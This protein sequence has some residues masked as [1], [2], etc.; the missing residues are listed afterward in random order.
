MKFIRRILSH[1]MLII[2][3]AG[4]VAIYYVRH[5]VLP[6]TLVEKIDH[7]A[8]M[9]HP[10]LV[11]FK[12]ERFNP[13][14][15]VSQERVT[16]EKRD[17]VSSDKR[18][19]DADVAIVDSVEEPVVV[20]IIE[21]PEQVKSTDIAE[22]KNVNEE[23]LTIEAV[24]DESVADEPVTD[25]SV[26]TVAEPVVVEKDN[27]AAEKPVEP[28]QVVVADSEKSV[29][30]KVAETPADKSAVVPA[31]KTEIKEV[32]VEKQLVPEKDLKAVLPVPVVEIESVTS[33][34]QSADY[35]Q[36]L[37]DAR[38][39]YIDSDFN[40]AIE[41]YK[42]LIGLE[43]HEADFY[44]ELGNVYY[45]MGNW[46]MAGEYYYEAALRLIDKGNTSQLSYLHRVIQGLDAGRAEKLSHL[47]TKR[48]R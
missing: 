1:M 29:E 8:G 28:K 27:K 47:I 48:V 39:A 23:S 25:D 19:E 12:N 4:I 33:D 35:K 38:L 44:G 2:L 24:A 22:A 41:K 5:Q 45:A 16:N 15:I 40:A 7:Y 20:E 18:V 31:D 32:V 13:V 42:E 10:S 34:R 46:S 26:T 21:K 17:V 11:R 30:V 14:V 43:E 37:T 3:L 6:E 9:A 36:I